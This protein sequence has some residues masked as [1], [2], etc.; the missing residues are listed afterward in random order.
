MLNALAP[1]TTVASPSSS[2]KDNSVITDGKDIKTLS[3]N[4]NN[5]K[6]DTDGV[7]NKN[8][9]DT[10]NS[11][12]LKLGANNSFFYVNENGSASANRSTSR[13]ATTTAT[14]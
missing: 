6:N 11:V 8:S 5:S 7:V 4:N 13:G 2:V 10:P 3:N 14:T 1:Q 12:T 9:F